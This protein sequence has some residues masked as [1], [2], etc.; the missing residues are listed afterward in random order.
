M[1]KRGCL[2][3]HFFCQSRINRDSIP[4]TESLEPEFRNREKLVEELKGLARVASPP[5]SLRCS[6]GKWDAAKIGTR[7]TGEILDAIFSPERNNC[8]RFVE[9]TKYSSQTAAQESE[10]RRREAKDRRFTR[11]ISVL[12][13]VI[14][15]GSLV[16]AILAL[17]FSL[18]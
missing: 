8:D 11:I 16:V 18:C 14:A 12:A 7:K 1:P 5:W 2:N 10:E 15:L 3:C 4:L 17:F 6:V 9:Y 13:I